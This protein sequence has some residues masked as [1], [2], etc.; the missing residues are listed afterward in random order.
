MG[1]VERNEVRAQIP[2]GEIRQGVEVAHREFGEG[3]VRIDRLLVHLVAAAH[4]VLQLEAVL[5]VHRVALLV[6]P[7]RC[8]GGADE[9]LGEPVEPRLE[10]AV[11]DVE[12]EVGELG[13]GPGVV[14]AP[15][16]AHE[17]LVFTGFGVGAGTEKQHMLEEMGHALAIRRIVEVAGIHRQ[18]G[19][20]FVGLGITDQQDPEPICQ[21]QIVIPPMVIGTGIWAHWGGARGEFI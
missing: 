15:V 4:V 7:L 2:A 1:F 10:E 6:D 17:L 13:T 19:G 21:L 9:E 20:G 3:V 16:T 8:K 12:E 18:G 14:A 5:G 11:V